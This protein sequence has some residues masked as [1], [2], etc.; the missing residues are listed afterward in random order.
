MV[1]ALYDPL[2]FPV[3]AAVFGVDVVV[4]SETSVTVKKNKNIMVN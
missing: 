1:F 3:G 4:V 2:F